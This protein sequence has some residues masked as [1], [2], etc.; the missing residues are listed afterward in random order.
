[1]AKTERCPR[2]AYDHVI[3]AACGVTMLTGTPETV[4]NRIGPPII[5]YLAGIY[6][7]FA[8]LAALRERDQTGLPQQVDVAMLDVALAAMASTVSSVANS[9]KVP[10]ANGHTAASGSPLSGIFPTANGLLSMTA[11]NDRQCVRIFQTLGWNEALN[12]P[13][14]STHAARAENVHALQAGL[15]QRLATRT[16]SEWENQFSAA[17][18]P[19]AKVRTIPEVLAEPHIVSRGVLQPVMDAVSGKAL[20]LSSIG[21]KW[22]GAP[23]GPRRMPP[24]L[25]EHTQAV[26]DALSKPSVTCKAARVVGS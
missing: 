25:G 17:H 19:V 14:F 22:N 18:V 13:R 15:I 26:L 12:D 4:P 24:R 11:N 3:Q 9:G 10:Q 8:V 1:M 2:P 7:A 23:L 6:G 16:A 20:Q 21:F 5:D